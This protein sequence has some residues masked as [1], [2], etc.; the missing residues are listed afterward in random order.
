MISRI[1]TSFDL[2]LILQINDKERGWGWKSWQVIQALGG[3]KNYN[4]FNYYNKLK[5]NHCEPVVTIVVVAVI[6]CV[7]RN[8][9]SDAYRGL[10]D[11]TFN[12]H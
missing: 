10:F 4:I 1:Q 12:C 8:L 2:V 3:K 6:V 11:S 9:F 7:R 5:Q